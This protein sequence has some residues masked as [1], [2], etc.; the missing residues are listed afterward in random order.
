[1]NIVQCISEQRFQDAENLIDEKIHQIMEQKLHELRKALAA[2]D[3]ADSYMVEDTHDLDEARR[4][5]IVRVRIRKG[6]VQRRK[7]V[8]NVK[9]WTFRKGKLTRMSP[10][11]RRHRRMGQRRGK[12]K[13]R[14]HR[15]VAR[16]HMKRALR[17]RH[18]LG[19]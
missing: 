1:M 14:A 19:L 16:L 13:R 2:K 11:E 7:K 4:Y 8:S 5:K 18:S 3:Y 9:G 12:I 15:N 10:T 17:K 6:K